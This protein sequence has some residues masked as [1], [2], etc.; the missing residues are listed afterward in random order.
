MTLRVSFRKES[1]G[2]AG[3][4]YLKAG[5]IDFIARP[6]KMPKKVLAAAQCLDSL[7]VET[8]YDKLSAIFHGEAMPDGN[9]QPDPDS[10][11]P[12]GTAEETEE[13][14]PAPATATGLGIAKGGTVEHPTHGTCTVVK[15]AGDGLTVTLEDEEEDY[16]KGIPVTELRPVTAG[17]PEV[18]HPAT[19]EPAAA[20]AEDGG[21]GGEP[22]WDD[23]GDD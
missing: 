22:E 12:W 17:A 21:S 14:P 7:L 20:P 10:E 8:P 19:P 6:S 23:W 4:P 16:H 13:A 2:G 9:G 18:E 3:N 5:S 11:A 15:V 1:Q